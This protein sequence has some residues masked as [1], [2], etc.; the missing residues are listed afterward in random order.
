VAI[1]DAYKSVDVVMED[2][3]DLVKVDRTLR[4]VLNVKGD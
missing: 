2:A 1:P 3:K 4:Q